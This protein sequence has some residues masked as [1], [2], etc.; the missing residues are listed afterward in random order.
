MIF[1]VFLRAVKNNGILKSRLN[2]II[3]KSIIDPY[4][5]PIDGEHLIS[6]KFDNTF[7]F[8]E[9]SHLIL[10]IE[11]DYMND[12][13]CFS[14]NSTSFNS[15][16]KLMCVNT[17]F[18]NEEISSI[19]NVAL[20]IHFDTS[21]SSF[22]SSKS[23]K[24]KKLKPSSFLKKNWKEKIANLKENKLKFF[25]SKINPTYFIQNE[26]KSAKSPLQNTN[27]LPNLSVF[28]RKNFGN[29]FETTRV[30]SNGIIINNR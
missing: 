27:L 16:E 11:E 18:K 23:C 1:L 30:K 19:Q 28:R 3:M 7:S 21:L 26:S 12:E 9:F 13:T 6:D 8:H 17:K 5:T 4:L 24:L 14:D 22:S 20:N 25:L 10:G 2:I 29:I 15:P